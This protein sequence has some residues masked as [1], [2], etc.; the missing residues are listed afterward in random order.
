MPAVSFEKKWF[1]VIDGV[2]FNLD[3]TEL[4]WCDPGKS[5]AYTVPDTVARIG[6]M[7]FMN[8]EE[9]TQIEISH[10]GT[11]IEDSAFFRCSKLGQV[12]FQGS[13]SVKYIKAHAFQ[14]CGK[15]RK[16]P[17][18]GAESIGDLAFF[19]CGCLRAVRVPQ[20]CGHI[21]EKAF[22]SCNALERLVV[23]EALAGFKYRRLSQ[24]KK[25]YEDFDSFGY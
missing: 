4:I 20:S 15:L 6:E 3:R 24:N 2:M 18:T 8:C 1:T 5:G 9:L 12:V 22:D 25:T 23:P 19:A 13:G 17:L 10:P 14:A 11:V 21:G 7:A 16:A